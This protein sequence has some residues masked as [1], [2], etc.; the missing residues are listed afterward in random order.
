M[1]LKRM[2]GV[3]S[4]SEAGSNRYPMSNGK[5]L[6]L[7]AVGLKKSKDDTK[8]M[9][10]SVVVTKSGSKNVVPGKS[11]ISISVSSKSSNASSKSS[12]SSRRLPEESSRRSSDTEMICQTPE[13]RNSRDAL[14]LTHC[15]RPG[16]HEGWNTPEESAPPAQ[17]H[18][19]NTPSPERR[20]PPPGGYVNY[21]E[22]NVAHLEGLVAQMTVGQMAAA[23]FPG[24]APQANN[25]AGWPVVDLG[26]VI[27]T[28]NHY[29]SEAN[30][31]RD[32]YLRSLMQP[33]DGWVS[34]AMIQ[35]FPRMRQLGVHLVALQQ[36]VVQ[37][38]QLELDV[39]GC[40]MR[41][42]DRRVRENFAPRV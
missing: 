13:S 8:P 10:V 28:L 29:F 25:A 37:S 35:M 39:S 15:R 30:L 26:E 17:Q 14:V 34:L 32:E 22:A 9:P 18:G 21:L 33:G 31:P 1:V 12:L 2:L 27:R 24:T 38:P 4:N 11:G 6:N 23:Q 7:S 36:A 40:Y 3:V 41:I 16:A 42:R 20:G 19:V 5:A